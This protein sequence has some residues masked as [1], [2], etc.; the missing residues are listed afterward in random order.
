[1][2]KRRMLDRKPKLI[3]RDTP[4]DGSKSAPSA[5]QVTHGLTLRSA[6]L[7]LAVLMGLKRVE[8]RHFSMRPGWYV[9]HTGTKMSSHE[10]QQALLASVPNMPAEA[11]L[12]HGAIVG[13]I[14]ISHVITLDECEETE[15]WAFGPVCN[16]IRSVARLE[17]PI[18]H[19]GALSL[20]S[21]G[22]EAID[23]VRLQLSQAVIHNNDLTHLPPPPAMF[24][25]IKVKGL[26]SRRY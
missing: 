21:I 1:M 19:A 10:S 2:A 5:P 13:A 4:G 16:V 25:K 7:T 17:R 18:L 11:A 23:E 22:S 6:Q 14:E 20:W 9:L 15:P 12:P 24:E 3:V 26:R 8:N